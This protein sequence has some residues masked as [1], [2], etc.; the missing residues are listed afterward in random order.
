MQWWQSFEWQV[1]SVLVSFLALVVSGISLWVAHLRGPN[2]EIARPGRTWPPKGEEFGLDAENYAL[3]VRILVANTGVKPGVLFGLQLE[4]MDGS[5]KG[6]PL[7]PPPEDSLPM[8]LEAGKGW[9]TVAKITVG[10]GAETWKEYTEK[11]KAIRMKISYLASCWTG[12]NKSKST[13]MDVDL[14]PLR[15]SIM[16]QM[17]KR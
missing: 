17:N 11:R 10:R 1:L 16:A 8:V 9:T 12:G 14:A 4:A 15:A 3:E 7:A 5:I 6:H 2:I 13:I